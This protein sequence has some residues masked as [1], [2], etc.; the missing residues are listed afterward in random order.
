MMSNAISTGS[1]YQRRA[2]VPISD[3]YS[4]RQ[5]SW[6]A[7]DSF[8]H[9]FFTIDDDEFYRLLGSG[10]IWDWNDR[11]GTY[12]DEY[13]IGIFDH[14]LETMLDEVVDSVGEG[15]ISDALRAAIAEGTGIYFVF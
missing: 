10:V 7:I 2:F 13:E 9:L 12:L 8:P 15:D 14:D 11:Y 4:S 6:G 1:D 3:F 5:F